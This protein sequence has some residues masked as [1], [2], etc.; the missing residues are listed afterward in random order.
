VVRRR[1]APAE[2]GSE[3]KAEQ[4][5]TEEMRLMKRRIRTAV[6]DD[7]IMCRIREKGKKGGRHGMVPPGGK[8]WP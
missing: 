7:C 5:A 6:V 1:A 2:E 4:R 8:G 3:G